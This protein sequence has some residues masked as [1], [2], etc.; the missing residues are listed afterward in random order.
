MQ[1]CKT[2]ADI[3]DLCAT[4]RAEGGTIGLVTTMGYLHDGHIELVRRAREANDRVI[5]T[6]FVNPTQFGANE[7][8]STYPAD[9]DR[10]LALLRAE[11]VDAVFNPSPDEM[12]VDGN[13]TIVET[14]KLSRVLIGKIRP[15]HFRG[16]ATIVTKLFNICQADRAYFGEKDYQQL[17]VINRM[18]ADLDMPVEIVGVPTVRE[19]D[20]LAMSSRNVRLTA[21]DR[22]AA[23]A[24]YHALL[25]AEEGLLAGP[26]TAH[27]LRKII[28]THLNAEPRAAVQSIDIRDAETLASI[29]GVITRPVVALLVVRFGAV[30][31][32]D[33]HVLTPSLVK[34]D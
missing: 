19:K 7:D 9:I 18:V 22:A 11:G 29:R 33:Q 21:E 20:G 17:M 25:E 1:I 4:F 31:L 26:L 16:V 13:Q 27:S 23:P 10:D 12:Y 14:T 34:K 32:I 5:V 8:L 6:I 28:S 24:L 2:K 3:R 30:L 15:G